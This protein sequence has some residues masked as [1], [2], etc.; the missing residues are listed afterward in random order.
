[1]MM[2]IMFCAATHR[3]DVHFNT[4][5]SSQSAQN[6]VEYLHVRQLTNR[7]DSYCTT[8]YSATCPATH[9][10]QFVIDFGMIK[11]VF[12]MEYRHCL[13]IR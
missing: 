4:Y 12:N 8:I 11:N 1:M 6:W 13:R 5:N 2:L 7:N 3:D 10:L 9:L